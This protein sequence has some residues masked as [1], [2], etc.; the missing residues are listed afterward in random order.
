MNLQRDDSI[1]SEQERTYQKNSPNS[2][3]FH[4]A[5]VPQVLLQC[6]VENIPFGPVDQVGHISRK[7]LKPSYPHC[8]TRE[9]VIAYTAEEAC[10]FDEPVCHGRSPIRINHY[11]RQFLESVTLGRT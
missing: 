3:L 7:G 5:H 8:S 2:G 9:S 10:K 11:L 6:P 1:E 4:S